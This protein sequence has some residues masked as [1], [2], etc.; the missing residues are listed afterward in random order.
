MSSSLEQMGRNPSREAVSRAIFACTLLIFIFIAGL[1]ILLSEPGAGMV[2]LVFAL[3]LLPVLYIFYPIYFM[4]LA[5]RY[6]REGRQ[7]YIFDKLMFYILFAALIIIALPATR[8]L[9]S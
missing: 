1:T 4:V 3:P 7:M 5:I 6:T 2:G 8:Q 9:L